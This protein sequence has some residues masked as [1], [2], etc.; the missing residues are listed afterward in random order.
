MN[1][2]E[3]IPETLKRINDG[4]TLELLKENVANISLKAV[5]GYGFIPKGKWPLPDGIPPYKEDVAPEGMTPGNLWSETRSFDRFMREDLSKSKREQM[6]IQ[7]LENIHP[8]EAKV[9]LAI[10][11]QTLS[12]M[13][14][15]ITLDKIVNAGFFIWPHGIDEDEYRARVAGEVTKVEVPLEVTKS[16]LPDSGLEKKR[17][18]PK[19]VGG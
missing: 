15:N 12:E 18:R 4:D 14:P 8:T 2:K 7:L 19:K 17:G 10:K 6:F 5:F 3:I 13:Y 16:N 11:D 1:K 9:V